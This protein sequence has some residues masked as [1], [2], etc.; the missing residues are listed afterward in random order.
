MKGI[1]YRVL[2]RIT[3]L[4]GRWFF[5]A[6]SRLIA[7]G[8][9]IF[10][11]RTFE[12]HRFY[13]ILFPDRSTLYH[14]WC[15]FRQYQIVSSENSQANLLNSSIGDFQTYLADEIVVGN[16]EEYAEQIKEM[17]PKLQSVLD[18]AKTAAKE[19]G[20]SDHSDLSSAQAKIDAIPAELK[21]VSGEVKAVQEEKA[22]VS[23]GIAGDTETLKKEFERLREKIF[24]K[25]TGTPIYYNDLKPVNE[26]LV[27]IEDFDKNDRVGA[28]K[29]LAVFSEK[30]GATR[31]EVTKK[32]DDSSAG[33]NFENLKK[34]I[35]NVDKTKTAMAEDLADKAQQKI[36]S[37]N[38]MHD[39]YRIKQHGI[40]EEWVATAEKFDPDNEKVKQIKED[41]KSKLAADLEKFIKKIENRKWA[42]H[43]ANAPKNAKKLAKTAI[44]WFKNNLEKIL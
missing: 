18:E 19:K 2:V 14:R 11:P 10:S 27:V 37:L 5:V 6:V 29:I 25:A 22:A 32:T 33:W 15:T 21:K 34:G 9:F 8:Y 35:E 23:A 3:R 31:E 40:I 17:L 26:L 13:S 30:Y 20:V 1:C 44:E 39:F 38:S 28:E 36:G 24:N 43:A 12:S 4:V 16:V 42:E 7:A 41:L